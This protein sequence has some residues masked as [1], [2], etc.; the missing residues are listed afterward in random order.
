MSHFARAIMA[1]CLALLPAAALAANDQAVVKLL[2]E[3]RHLDLIAKGAEV[4]YRFEKK[5]SDERLVGKDQKDELRLGVSSVNGKGERDVVFRVFSG[6]EARDPQNWPEL[7][8]NP[9]FVWYLDR[10]VTT[11][12]YL[13]GGN[14]RYLKAKFREALRERAEMEPI[15]YEFG[16]KTIK[17][18]KVTVRPYADDWPNRDKMQGFENTEF[19]I[20]VSDEAPGYFVNLE[21]HFVSTHAAAPSIEEKITLVGMGE[22]K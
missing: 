8:I 15:D 5:G 2:F 1:L 6:E 22:T 12:Q 4:T 16:G 13:A 17:A 19:N 10:A 11:F 7:T 14:A 18:Y 21:L 20:I 9:L 3:T